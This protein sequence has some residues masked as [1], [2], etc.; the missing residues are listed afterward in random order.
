[1]NHPRSIC[2]G[3]SPTP[4]TGLRPED[5]AAPR[6]ACPVCPHPSDTHDTIALRY[7]AATAAGTKTRGCV[8]VDPP[9]GPFTQR[10]GRAA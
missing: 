10:R 4:V 8:C 6:P 5:A 2:H 9:A 1:M 3:E 7:C